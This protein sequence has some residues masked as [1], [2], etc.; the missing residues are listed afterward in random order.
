M[1]DR[2][3]LRP[4]TATLLANLREELK[5]T[6]PDT[7]W[8][9]IT[10]LEILEDLDSRSQ[11][12]ADDAEDRATRRRADG[13]RPRVCLPPRRLLSV[14]PHARG[15]GDPRPDQ[16]RQD[17]TM[18]RCRLPVAGCQFVRPATDN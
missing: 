13:S 17:G 11:E 6:V 9:A 10:M 8:I 7:R 2:P 14:P 15:P 1:T 16:A 3:P 12:P 18:T 5:R 4:A